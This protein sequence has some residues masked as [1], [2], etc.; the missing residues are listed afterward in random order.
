MGSS[1]CCRTSSPPTRAEQGL[2]HLT[3]SSKSFPLRGGPG[4]H[5]HTTVA[6]ARTS[7]QSTQ[8]L[9]IACRG[10]GTNPP[11]LGG[12]PAP[13]R[14]LCPRC[15]PGRSPRLSTRPPQTWS[16]TPFPPS[17]AR[18]RRQ[19]APSILNNTRDSGTLSSCPV[20]GR[21]W[22]TAITMAIRVLRV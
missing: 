1:L 18:R 8:R 5:E 2:S 19:G 11:L 13:T 14:R 15:H 20:V 16:I 22:V 9:A 21:V 6:T 4:R 10:L 7:E 17:I 3:C 12:H